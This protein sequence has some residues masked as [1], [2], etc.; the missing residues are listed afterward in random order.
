M[1]RRAIFIV[2]I[3]V[4]GAVNVFAQWHQPSGHPTQPQPMYDT[5]YKGPMNVYGQPVYSMEP[6]RDDQQT[7]Q[8]AN[9]GVFPMAATGLES[10]GRYFWS[11]MPAPVRGAPEQFGP[12]PGSGYVVRQVVPGSN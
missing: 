4:I 6:R 3:C 5:S 8:N 9:N 2:A 7:A 10:L 1:S 12:P 11:Y